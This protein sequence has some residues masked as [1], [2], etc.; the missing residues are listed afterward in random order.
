MNSFNSRSVQPVSIT[1]E[2][3][4]DS[5][6]PVHVD[7]QNYPAVQTVKYEEH[8]YDSFNKI[9]VSNPY[10]LMEYTH[11]R[12]DDNEQESKLIIGNAVETHITPY[13][14]LDVLGNGD[15]VFVQS[16]QRGIYQAG[17]SLSVLI[18][19]VMNYGNNGIGVISYI[20]YYDNDDG[21]YIR[22]DT[23][24]KWRIVRRSSVTGVIVDDIINQN[25]FNID[26]MDGTGISGINLDASKCQLFGIDLSWLGVNGF[27]IC[28]YNNGKPYYLHKQYFANNNLNIPY[29]KIASLPI[30][31]GI[32]SVSGSGSMIQNCAT[33][34]SESGYNLVGRLNYV[35]SGITV[36]TIGVTMTPLIVL[37]LKSTGIFP[38]VNVYILNVGI[39]S[40]STNPLLHGLVYIF[41]DK[42]N[43]SFLTGSSFISVNNESAVE[44]DISS[45][46]INISGS[47]VLFGG[48]LTKNQS[49]IGITSSQ[50]KDIV[51]T[52]NIIG[53]SDYIAV[54]A[55]TLSGGDSV[56]SRISWKEVI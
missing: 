48:Y 13:S 26:R 42:I 55:Q 39:E 50:E 40:N 29:M 14:K 15:S 1:N 37:R 18:T 46:A 11:I 41:R 27:R 24:N 7:I 22:W 9:R 16:R 4:L 25:D 6:I 32:S 53:N 17:K 33:I 21:I 43:A 56:L 52:T 3:V 8:I 10:N 23:I 51:L 34:S 31:Y 49:E 20:G 12:G 28:T 2:V 35:D 19:A 38:K 5:D 47:K 30:R 36:K 54:C 45:T 44:Y